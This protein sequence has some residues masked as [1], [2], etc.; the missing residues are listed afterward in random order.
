M[1]SVN[2]P[3]YMIH[4]AIIILYFVLCVVIARISWYLQ[5]KNFDEL[6]KSYDIIEAEN[7]VYLATLLVN[8][9]NG[10]SDWIKVPEKI[11]VKFAPYSSRADK[12]FERISKSHVRDTYREEYLKFTEIHTV[13]ERLKGK[14]FISF[15][16]ENQSGNWIS[17][18]IVSQHTD[19]SGKMNSVLYLI[20]DVTE[21]M[22]KEKEYQRQLKITGEAKTNFLRR[23]SHDIRTPINGIRGII[24]I[25][26]H[27][28]DNQKLQ[29]ECFSK[30]KDGKRIFDGACQ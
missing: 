12:I 7:K 25:A 14:N 27:N 26:E 2:R 8:L 16:Y 18:K 10:E 24:E 29:R 17:V 4:L 21:E 30:S 11:R 28:P 13:E 23:M 15:T 22:K 19:Q 3:Y 5:K 6:K 9:K 1:L 20:S